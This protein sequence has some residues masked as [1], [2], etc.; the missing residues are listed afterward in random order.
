MTDEK[1]TPDGEVVQR[2][3]H[4]MFWFGP[5]SKEGPIFPQDEV[6]WT[7]VFYVFTWGRSIK[8]DSQ[9]EKVKQEWTYNQEESPSKTM[10]KKEKK[11]T[12]T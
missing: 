12:R 2:I 6:A 11:L 5:E 1:P 7:P 9:H 10:K 3:L 8:N 4:V